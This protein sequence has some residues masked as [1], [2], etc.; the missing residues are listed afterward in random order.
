MKKTLLPKHYFFDLP[1]QAKV[2][3]SHHK[4]GDENNLIKNTDF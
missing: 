2:L 4:G 1:L 3:H